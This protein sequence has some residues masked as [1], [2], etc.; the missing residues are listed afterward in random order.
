MVVGNS[1][2]ACNPWND[3]VDASAIETPIPTRKFHCFSTTRFSL[4]AVVVYTGHID[5][6]SNK[7][8]FTMHVTI[9]N[10][11]LNPRQ[12]KMTII[13]EWKS[14]NL[15]LLSCEITHCLQ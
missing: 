1:I 3:S 6:I 14:K 15:K 12:Y 13:Y 2:F 11:R 5:C 8:R 7:E 4:D 10:T 9:F